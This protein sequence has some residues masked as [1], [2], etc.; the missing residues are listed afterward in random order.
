MHIFFSVYTVLRILLRG[1]FDMFYLSR[2][3]Y[4]MTEFGLFMTSY[5]RAG[6]GAKLLYIIHTKMH[7]ATPRIF[8]LPV[9]AR[10]EFQG[11]DLQ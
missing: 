9:Y 5:V 6:V 10:R 1:F 7:V 2:E 8:A 11:S 4:I 3:E